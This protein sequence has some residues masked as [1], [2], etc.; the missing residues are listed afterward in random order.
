MNAEIWNDQTER[1]EPIRS[2]EDA[3]FFFDWFM[4]WFETQ[5]ILSGDSSK[6]IYTVWED[7]YVTM[8]VLHDYSCIRCLRAGLPQIEFRA[9]EQAKAIMESLRQARQEMAENAHKQYVK[10]VRR[11]FELIVTEK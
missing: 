6:K 10:D 9:Y 3:Q 4:D 2:E 5:K 7:H 8:T 11:R 1:F